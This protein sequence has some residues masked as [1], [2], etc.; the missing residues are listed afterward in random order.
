M[1]IWIA[2]AW[3]LLVLGGYLAGYSEGL[4]KERKSD[5]GYL[6]APALGC[7]AVAMGIL[8]LTAF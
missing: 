7:F 4:K 1:E 2:A 6:I 8:V 3:G 5:V